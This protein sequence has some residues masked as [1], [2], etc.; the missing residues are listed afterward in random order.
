MDLILRSRLLNRIV[1]QILKV[2]VLAFFSYLRDRDMFLFQFLGVFSFCVA[3]NDWSAH[4]EVEIGH[5]FNIVKPIYFAHDYLFIVSITGN[6]KTKSV[7]ACM[8]GFYTGLLKSSKLV[9]LAERIIE[10]CHLLT[11]L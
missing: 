2:S 9:A 5:L 3:K 1:F 6:D 8:L 10:I 11:F 7:P 4:Y